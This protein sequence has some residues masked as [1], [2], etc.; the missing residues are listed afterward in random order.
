MNATEDTFFQLMSNFKNAY[1]YEATLEEITH[2]PQRLYKMY[3]ELLEGYKQSPE[4]IL[5]KRF[6]SSKED[7][8]I[9]KDIEFVSLCVHHWLPFTGV[10]HVGYIPDHKEVVGLSKIPRLVHCFA[11]R[12]QIQE[13]MTSEIA[14]A[15]YKILKPK[16]CIVI[17]E[18][19]HLCSEIRG[20][21]TRSAMVVS[22]IRG[23]FEAPEIRSE[24]LK[25]VKI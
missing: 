18:A 21:Q 12:F 5:S 13:Q 14:D 10:A 7:M 23:C 3:A 11:R 19:R 22:A 8:I 24:F 17:T 20:V 16:G 15:L 9:I 6:P 1:G 2:T 25:L 4:E